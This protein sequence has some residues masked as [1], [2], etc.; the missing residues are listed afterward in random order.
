MSQYSSTS[1]C[2]LVLS[3]FSELV[4]E[5]VNKNDDHVPSTQR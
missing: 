1:F 3:H 2:A 4:S 5:M